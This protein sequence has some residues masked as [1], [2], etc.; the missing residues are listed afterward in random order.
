MDRLAVVNII[1][2]A[3]NALFAAVMLVLAIAAAAAGA[4]QPPPL[5]PQWGA[6]VAARGG[7][8]GAALVLA[9]AAPII[10]NGFACHQV[11]MWGRG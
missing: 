10:L 3:A 11:C 6:L 5:W 9:S 4:A 8:L 7:G 1:G 2:V